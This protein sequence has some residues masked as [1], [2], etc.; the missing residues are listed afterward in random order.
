M[1]GVRLP[2]V[3][4]DNPRAYGLFPSPRPAMD[5]PPPRV[6]RPARRVRRPHPLAFGEGRLLVEGRVR[7]RVPRD[8]LGGNRRGVPL[9]V[10]LR[11]REND[12][13]FYGPMNSTEFPTKAARTAFEG[14]RP[15]S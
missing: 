7:R 2:A 8:G 15:R 11:G 5:A 9:R 14:F 10:G 12:P 13:V 3:M 1:A 4:C 6:R